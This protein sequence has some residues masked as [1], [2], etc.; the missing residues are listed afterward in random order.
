MALSTETVIKEELYNALYNALA[1]LS[2]DDQLLLYKLYVKNSSLRGA[3]QNNLNHP[4]KVK[5][6]QQALLKKLAILLKEY[7][8]DFFDSVTR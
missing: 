3:M 6:H 8:E 4:T 2:I 5:R 7:E 1:T